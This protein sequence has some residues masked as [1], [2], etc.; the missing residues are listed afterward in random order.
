MAAIRS[1]RDWLAF[2]V[3]SGACIVGLYMVVESWLDE[4]SVGPARARIFAAYVTSTLLA[5]F[6]IYPMLRRGSP[7]AELH[8]DDLPMVRTTPL[9]LEMHP[10]AEP[11][12]ELGLGPPQEP[13]PPGAPRPKHAMP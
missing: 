10:K 12:Q 9:A 11:E 6:A 13:S 7:P 3:L 5:V 1:A 2:R 4:Q 8:S